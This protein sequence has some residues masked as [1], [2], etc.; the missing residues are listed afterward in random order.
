MKPVHQFPKIKLLRHVS[1]YS[2]NLYMAG[3]RHIE[4]ERFSTPGG[5]EGSDNVRL[6][7]ACPS[8]HM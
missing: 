4:T 1:G 8:V 6:S 5:R 2:Y 7:F 3:E